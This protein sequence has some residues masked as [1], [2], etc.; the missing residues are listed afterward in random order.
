MER[1]IS[2]DRTIIPAADEAPLISL[3]KLLDITGNIPQIEAIKIGA[4]LVE[5]Y[6]LLPVVDRIRTKQSNLN[7]IYDRQKAGSDPAHTVAAMMKNYRQAG[8]DCVIIFPFAGP[9]S[10]EAW[11]KESHDS[12]IIPM[13]GGEMSVPNYL[14]KDNG[15]ISNKAPDRIYTQALQLG[16]QHLVVPG[17]KPERIRYY[18]RLTESITSDEIDFFSPGFGAQ[19]GSI[20][21]ASTISG[22]FHPIVGRDIA[23]A[24][25]PHLATIAL[26]K[27]LN[28]Q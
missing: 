28:E 15:Y 12:G 8:I 23:N 19:L 13:V 2:R 26:I 10:L 9:H 11:V 1:L 20:R 6:G 4:A 27:Q 22:R 25:N 17:N 5:S 24:E 18:R 21:E 7:I 16:V 3:D 14:E